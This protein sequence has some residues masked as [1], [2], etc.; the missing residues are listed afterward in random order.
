LCVLLL[1]AAAFGQEAPQKAPLSGVVAG[2]AVAANEFS[3]WA[4]AVQVGII[5]PIDQS[6]GVSA[7]TLYT[8]ASFGHDEYIESLRL[9]GLLSWHIG[10][11]WEFYVPLGADFYTG[12]AEGGVDAFGGLGT[13]VRLHTAHNQDYLVPFSIDVFAEAEFSDVD[14]AK[15]NLAHLTF[16]L[17]FAKPVK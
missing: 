6:K 9:T 5:T 2:S 7:R 15:D 16:G 10:K 4:G 17:I 1:A 8:K 3:N 14:E 13:M 11:G 12:G